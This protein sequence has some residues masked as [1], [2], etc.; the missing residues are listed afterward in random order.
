[1]KLI[2]LYLNDV[3]TQDLNI[4]YLLTFEDYLYIFL[5]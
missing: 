1:M 5:S 3:V 4:E 2:F